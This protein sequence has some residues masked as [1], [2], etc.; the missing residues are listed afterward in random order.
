[1]ND[2]T[3]YCGFVSIIGRP[4]VGKSTL[5]NRIIGE[6]IC[7]TSK[8]PQTTRD[9]IMGIKTT[10][11][12]QIVFIDTPGIHK[13]AKKILNKALN[14]TAKR[15]LSDADIILFVIEAGNWTEEEDLIMKYLETVKCPVM[16]IINKIDL[17]TP[18]EKLLPYIE[19][20]KQALPYSEIILVSAMKNDNLELLEESLLEKLP[21]SPFYYYPEDKTDKQIQFRISEL[22]REQVFRRTGQELPY[23]TA[24]ELEKM[25]NK[26]NIL[27]IYATIWIERKGQKK[28]IIGE[29]GSKL[30]E[31]G[32]HA[33]E[34]IE[35]MV[36]QQIYLNLW[37]KV[38]EN[39]SDDKMFI[40]QMG[41]DE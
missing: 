24:V 7:I 25:E 18:K 29:K 13:N 32:Q 26:K 5:L 34:T 22:I 39:W 3:T 41:L 8:K 2:K 15:T 35:Q 20:C 21:E 36:A 19:K 4:N 30:K 16:L 11:N 9:R 12:K 27:H 23:S 6:K 28:I 33:R 10:E 17:I 31:I 14:K 37:V 38:K 1:M 40:R